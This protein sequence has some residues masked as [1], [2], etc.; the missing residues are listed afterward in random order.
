M[1]NLLKILLISIVYIMI[2]SN[3]INA[4]ETSDAIGNTENNPTLQI[5]CW[6]WNKND[7]NL[8]TWIEKTKNSLSWVENTR[9]FSEYIQS[10]IIYILKFLSLIAVIYIIYAWFI[11]LTWLWEEEKL[12]T[13]K[14]TIVYVIAWLLIIWSAYSIVILIINILN[15]TW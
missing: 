2:Y 13:A 4:S 3:L 5:E 10:I 8:K 7:C 14:K 11:V 6:I 1:L 15:T 12:K 9:T